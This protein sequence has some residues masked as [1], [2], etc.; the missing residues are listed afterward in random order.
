MFAGMQQQPPRTSNFDACRKRVHDDAFEAMLTTHMVTP[1]LNDLASFPNEDVYKIALFLRRSLTRSLALL[2][3]KMLDKPNERGRT[4]VTASIGALLEMAGRDQLLNE[5][6]LR[7]LTDRFEQIK[8]R[9]Q[10]SGSL[11]EALTDLRTIHVA[12]SL[13][14]HEDPANQVWARELVD[15]ALELFSFVVTIEE[16]L[17]QATGTVLPDLVENAAAFRSN[18]DRLWTMLKSLGGG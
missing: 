8:V 12:H 17:S 2:L 18:A 6:Q 7:E 5:N 3:W 13:V 1:L 16:A 15:F 9:A 11:I 10:A 4:G 14:P